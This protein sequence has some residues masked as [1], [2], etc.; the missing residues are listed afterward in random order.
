LSRLGTGFLDPNWTSKLGRRPEPTVDFEVNYEP[1][2]ITVSEACRLVWK[3][4]DIMPG[5]MVDELREFGL[6]TARMLPELEPC[7]FG[8][9]ESR[10]GSSLDPDRRGPP[11]PPAGF[12]FALLLALVRTCARSRNTD[13]KLRNQGW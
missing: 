13:Q 9:K 7:A 10:R 6:R 11:V 8:L 2:P 1:R 5:W 4:T 12:L 3:C